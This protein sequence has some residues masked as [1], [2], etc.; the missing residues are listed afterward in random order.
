MRDW[1][2]VAVKYHREN[3]KVKNNNG[4]SSVFLGF[5]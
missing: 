2:N 3:V 4:K 1:K 5:Q